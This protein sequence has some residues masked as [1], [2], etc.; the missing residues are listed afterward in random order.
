MLKN[1]I[2]VE[3]P[4]SCALSVSV[5]D[6][7]VAKVLGA[8]CPKGAAYAVLEIQEPV[9]ILTTTVAAENLS[10]KF[11]PVRTNK[12][13]PKRYISKAMDMIRRMRIVAPVKVGDAISDNFLEMDIKVLA[14]RDAPKKE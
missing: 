3:C 1:M 10:L 7:V 14:T 8:K 2:C 6:G 9:R 4:K 11:V 5:D 13:I 12:P